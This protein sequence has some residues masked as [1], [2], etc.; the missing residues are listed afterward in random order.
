MP[1]MRMMRMPARKRISSVTI[2]YQ[3]K[4]RNIKMQPLRRRDTEE[5]AE[6]KYWPQIQIRFTQMNSIRD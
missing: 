4:G 1:G 6:K 5:D 2:G 3:S